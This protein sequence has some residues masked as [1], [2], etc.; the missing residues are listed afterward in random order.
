M[1]LTFG[2]RSFAQAKLGDKRRSTRLAA[3]VDRMCRHPGGS[4]PDKL[5]EPADLRAFY[6]L[7]NRP[8]VTHT[9]LMASHADETRR[10]INALKDGTVVLN[11][12][13]ATE[14]DYSSK[15][16][17]HEELAQIGNGNGLGFICHNSLAVLANS[18]ETL[19]LLS[20]I[21]HRR[22]EAPKNEPLKVRRERESRESR[23]WVE[24]VKRS[25]AVREGLMCVDV[26]DS[27]SDTFEYMAYEVDQGRHFVLRAKENRALHEPLCNGQGEALNEERYLF[28]AVRRWPSM[29]QRTIQVLASPGR[30]A[31]KTTVEVSFAKACLAL[32]SKH[33]GEYP[34]RPLYL[35]VVRVWEPHTPEGEEPLEWILLTNVPASSAA[36]AQQRVDWYERRP[37]I[38]ELHKGMKTG[39]KLEALQFTTTARLEPAIAVLSAVTTTLL[40]LRDAARADD[41]DKRPASEVVALEYVETLA[42]HY[43]KRV[44]PN[45]TIRMFYFHVARLGGHQNR[46]CDGFPGWITLWRGWMKLESMVDGYRAAQRNTG[47]RCG[48]S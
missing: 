39:C 43:G 11:L 31:R 28:D 46:K 24:G 14:L 2:F 12:H 23:L 32:P 7:M 30:Q 27:L 17:L 3:L 25:G 36:Q 9:A 4:L 5:K 26:S 41:A 48:K 22:A 47:R 37:I 15:K 10:S 40:R 38:E 18:G 44:G 1:A 8:E 29:G 6:R 33:L 16:S 45:P 21:L 13:D 34:K 19:G 35:W 42:A 20:Q